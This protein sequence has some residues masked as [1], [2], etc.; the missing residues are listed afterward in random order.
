[1]NELIP[2]NYDGENQTV[3]GRELHEFLEVSEKYTDWFKR[4][5]D[6]GFSEIEDFTLVSEKRA[7]NNPKNP[8]TTIADHKITIEMAKEIAMLQR[9]EKGKQARQYFIQLEKAWNS[10]EQIMARAIQIANKQISGLQL[11]LEAQHPKVIFA[12]SVATSKTSILIGELAK[13]IKG[14]GADIGEKRFFTWLRDNKFL[15]SRKGTD[16]NAP[17][18]K[19]MELSLF[20]VKETVI[21]HSD[22]HISINKTTK[23]TGKGQIYFI[24]KFKTALVLV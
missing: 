7:T 15:I 23:V 16:Y 2:V 20:R 17:T 3:S 13:I 18:Q 24:N 9:T 12:D 6:Y 4:M 1:M 11:Q 14:N 8:L 10:P 22:G 5:A 21:T 19:S